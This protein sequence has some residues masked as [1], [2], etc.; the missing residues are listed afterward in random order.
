MMDKLGI[1]KRQNEGRR[2]PVSSSM[3]P[4]FRKYSHSKRYLIDRFLFVCG[5]RIEFRKL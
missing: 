4:F 1:R 5:K 2:R 3:L